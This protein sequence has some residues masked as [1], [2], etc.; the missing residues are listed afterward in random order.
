MTP[1][2]MAQVNNDPAIFSAYYRALEHVLPLVSSDQQFVLDQLAQLH[3]ADPGQVFTA[4]L[5]LDHVGAFGHSQGGAT[6]MHL[7]SVDPRCKAALSL[8]GFVLGSIE[9]KG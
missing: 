4:R 8:D 6:V 7:C 5:D 3:H 2:L 1:E 9:Q